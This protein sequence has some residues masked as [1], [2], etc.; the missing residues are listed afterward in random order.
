MTHQV[1]VERCGQ[2]WFAYQLLYLFADL[3]NYISEAQFLH[4]QITTIIPTSHG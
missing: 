2:L 1:E 3:I 4:H